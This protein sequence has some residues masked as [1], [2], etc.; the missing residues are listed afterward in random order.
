MD[1]VNR[2]YLQLH[3]SFLLDHSV[4]APLVTLYLVQTRRLVELITY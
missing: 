1:N 4:P 2:V 3:V